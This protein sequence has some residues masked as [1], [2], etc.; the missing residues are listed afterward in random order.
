MA[1]EARRIFDQWKFTVVIK[2]SGCG[3]DA[4]LSFTNM[5]GETPHSV[6]NLRRYM[7]E[8]WN[9]GEEKV[10]IGETVFTYA[11]LNSVIE[12][13]DTKYAP[14]Q[15]P[16]RAIVMGAL[17]LVKPGCNATLVAC[18]GELE[19]FQDPNLPELVRDLFRVVQQYIFSV[20][21]PEEH[22]HA[23]TK[24]NLLPVKLEMEYAVR[25]YTQLDYD[26]HILRNN[27]SA[28]FAHPIFVD[29]LER[30]M[31]SDLVAPR[32]H[33]RNDLVKKIFERQ[34][35][36]TGK[37][38]IAQ[39]KEISRAFEERRYL[40]PEEEDSIFALISDEFL[41][42]TSPASLETVPGLL[43]R[44]LAHMSPHQLLMQRGPVAMKAVWCHLATH[45]RNVSPVQL[46]TLLI[47]PY[48]QFASVKEGVLDAMTLDADERKYTL[49]LHF[50]DSQINVAR[51]PEPPR[52]QYANIQGL[53]ALEG[54]FRIAFEHMKEWIAGAK[55]I[56]RRTLTQN[57]WHAARYVGVGP[58]QNTIRFHN[59]RPLSSYELCDQLFGPT[60]SLAFQCYHHLHSWAVMSP[61]RTDRTG[62]RPFKLKAYDLLFS[63]DKPESDFFDFDMVFEGTQL[64][65]APKVVERAKE[66]AMYT[67]I[68][69]MVV[70]N[71]VQDNP[72]WRKWT[73]LPAPVVCCPLRL[74]NLSPFLHDSRLREVGATLE[75]NY[76]R[77]GTVF[78]L[79]RTNHVRHDA[80]EAMREAFAL[81][82]PRTP[83]H[84]A[85]FAY[86]LAAAHRASSNE[87]MD[88]LAAH[89]I[90]AKEIDFVQS[91]DKQKPCGIHMTWAHHYF[92]M[93]YLD[94]R[95]AL[96]TTPP[97][98]QP[99]PNDCHLA[100][101][102]LVW[103]DVFAFEITRENDNYSRFPARFQEILRQ[104][105][106]RQVLPLTQIAVHAPD[107]LEEANIAQLEQNLNGSFP[108]SFIEQQR[109]KNKQKS[110]P[111]RAA[112]TTTIPMDPKLREQLMR[113]PDVDVPPDN[114]KGTC[115][116]ASPP[117][118]RR[119][120]VRGQRNHD[121]W[122]VTTNALAVVR[123]ATT[124]QPTLPKDNKNTRVA[125][126]PKK[127]DKGTHGLA[128]AISLH[129]PSK[130]GK[131][132]VTEKMDVE[133]EWE[134]SSVECGVCFEEKERVI[135][136]PC[137]HQAACRDCAEDLL[138]RKQ[139]CP[140]CRKEIDFH[141][142]PIVP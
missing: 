66:I 54:S 57:I 137:Q 98:T 91:D 110:A 21:L 19:G 95:K 116:P 114:V 10:T 142:V 74:V 36:P 107:L 47:A 83:A 71:E 79:F 136:M 109:V 68:E 26:L 67:W 69:H 134:L 30:W 58:Y 121:E 113:I 17:S 11:E 127:D 40:E 56:H 37:R 53:R 27:I 129:Q 1:F 59:K 119:P 6:D 122:R 126:T 29:V 51:N 63:I 86:L 41:D 78:S 102:M 105:P 9:E 80:S 42:P 70:R 115:R 18:R 72:A 97:L 38:T 85:M 111:T 101:Y 112:G 128:K 55:N 100:E 16:L 52:W 44:I 84:D 125:A 87:D 99:I 12:D 45:F 90:V 103:S 139:P 4:L 33:L 60:F 73:N 133:E 62:P 34:C 39:L 25:V 50:V 32:I 92:A 28:F 2:V 22:T 64:D 120:A 88:L 35:W 96:A 20:V 94:P 46:F 135:F 75:D 3:S 106:L 131:E 81:L 138:Q 123:E 49:A 89:E 82:K 124:P 5:F 65:Y 93:Q 108:Q 14:V 141:F 140:Y 23:F 13:G 104:I 76:N 130:K 31:L 8:Y 117:P 77:E 61:I 43:E 24:Q 7:N 118:P 15:S 132:P 48:K